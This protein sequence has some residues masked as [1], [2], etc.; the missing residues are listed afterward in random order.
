MSLA[1]AMENLLDPDNDFVNDDDVSPSAV[2]SSRNKPAAPAGSTPDPVAKNATIVVKKTSQ[3]KMQMPQRPNGKGEAEQRT[4]QSLPLLKL[5]QKHHRNEQVKMHMP[6]RPNGKMEA[7]QKTKQSL[8][9][10]KLRQNHYRN[11]QEKKSNTEETRTAT[12]RK[13]RAAGLGKIFM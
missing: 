13:R 11:G 9:L 3:M 1:A 12:R 8:P 10:L 4:K 7:G 2:S 6:Q 5:R